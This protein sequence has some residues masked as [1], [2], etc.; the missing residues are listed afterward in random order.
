MWFSKLPV[1]ERTESGTRVGGGKQISDCCT[2]VQVGE[3]EYR[4]IKEKGKKSGNCPEKNRLTKLPLPLPH[5]ATP[6]PPRSRPSCYLLESRISPRLK[7][8][9]YDSGLCTLVQMQGLSLLL[10]QSFKHSIIP[11]INTS[12]VK[13]EKSLETIKERRNIEC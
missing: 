3:S 2:G 12:P 13:L 10:H 6:P 4:R 5:S 8:Q 1:P 11:F 7:F 9:R